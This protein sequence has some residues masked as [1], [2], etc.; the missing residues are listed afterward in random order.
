MKI[1]RFLSVI[2][3]VMICISL[4]STQSVQATTSFPVNA[5]AIKTGVWSVTIS[6]L[7]G[8]VCEGDPYMLTATW[9]LAD[10]N[11]LL[12]PLVGPKLLVKAKLGSFDHETERPGTINGTTMFNYTAEKEGT[13]TI[14]I[15]L[16]DSDLEVDA[17]YSTSFEVKKCNYLYTLFARV[18]YQTPDGTLA[19]YELLKSKG[20]L[21]APDPNR[22]QYREAYNK[23]ITDTNIITQF[24]TEECQVNFT[25]PGYALGFV[26]SKAVEADNGM[27]IKL[28]IG[29]PINF[30]WLFDAIITCPEGGSRV[31]MT[32][33]LT[34][35]KDPWIEKVFPFSEGEYDITIDM[36]DK[37]I[38]N[39][40]SGGLIASYT[41]KLSLTRE[42]A[43]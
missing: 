34:T 6:G 24:P 41:A 12:A 16:F 32:Y 19:W 35:S 5:K 30:T 13:E 31:N 11:A 9:G 28:M 4:F 25:E 43:K 3:C 38:E 18:D 21:T 22:P 10:N 33:P 1:Y 14:T 26:D 40:S 8:T 20:L 17:E 37:H 36:L 23:T 29:P 7:D 2:M 39:A 27:G 15:Q 42:E